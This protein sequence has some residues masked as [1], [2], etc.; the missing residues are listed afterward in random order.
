[1]K[2]ISIIFLL[3]LLTLSGCVSREDFFDLARV[4]NSDLAVISCSPSDNSIDIPVN[5]TITVEFSSVMDP[6][7]IKEAFHLKYDNQTISSYDGVFHPFPDN[8]GFI[9]EPNIFFPA[10][11]E[12]TVIIDDSARDIDDF[13]LLGGFESHFSTISDATPDMLY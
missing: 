3:L 1:M 10:S 2:R 9:F 6:D 4:K 12:I 13:T 7:S 11:T 5:T 8:K